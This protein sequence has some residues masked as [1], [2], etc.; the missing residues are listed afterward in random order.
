MY[1]SAQDRVVE[2][3]VMDELATLDLLVSTPLPGWPTSST[4]K[5]FLASSGPSLV[6]PME[7][8]SLG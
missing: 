8:L 6:N 2:M 3:H 5:T 1:G 4:W 7:S